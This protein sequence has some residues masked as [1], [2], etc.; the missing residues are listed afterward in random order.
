MAPAVKPLPFLAKASYDCAGGTAAVVAAGVS[1]F[2][3]L[4]KPRLN[5]S[6]TTERHKRGEK[7][8]KV[9]LALW[10]N[11]EMILM[12]CTFLGGNRA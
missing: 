1:C 10:L 6:A 12:L 11:E 2:E 4:A 8:E 7:F 5:A 3:Q 9:M